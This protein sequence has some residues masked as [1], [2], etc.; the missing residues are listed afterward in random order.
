MDCD[1]A[2]KI[3]ERLEYLDNTHP[4]EL[5]KKHTYTNTKNKH[6]MTAFKN[7]IT[8]KLSALIRQM[9]YKLSL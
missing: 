6:T 9:S 7:S 2:K 5:S 3:K 4:T 8:S 1:L